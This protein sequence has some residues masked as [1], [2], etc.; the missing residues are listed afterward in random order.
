M[1]RRRMR[2]YKNHSGNAGFTL[3]EMIVVLAVVM[4]LLRAFVPRFINSFATGAD[5]TVDDARDIVHLLETGRQYAVSNREHENWGIHLVDNGTTDCGSSTAVDCVVLFKGTDFASRDSSY[6]TR[7]TLRANNYLTDLEG[8]D[9][10]F[11]RYSGYLMNT[12]GLPPNPVARYSMESYSMTRFYP[13]FGWYAFQD[14]F[15]VSGNNNTASGTLYFQPAYSVGFNG[16]SGSRQTTVANSGT[17]E[18]IDIPNTI[19]GHQA[20]TGFTYAMEV[21][22]TGSYIQSALI[23]GSQT[24]TDA[25]YKSGGIYID[26]SNKPTAVCYDGHDYYTAVASNPLV[27]ASWY[28]IAATYDASSSKLKL[29]IDGDEAAATTVTCSGESMNESYIGLNSDNTNRMNS[30][31]YL[32]DVFV[33]DR[34]LTPQQI[35]GLSIFS[36]TTTT[37]EFVP[38]KI[39]VANGVSTTTIQ[40]DSTGYADYY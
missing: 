20:S 22:T 7:V 1:L 36:R 23:G 12:Y 10:Y 14:L 21:G 24:T 26:A 15:D 37:N 19:L 38:S 31:A 28:H 2:T 11:E 33:Y 40:M 32:D 34:P 13:D 29:Y 4:L 39:Y 17:G 16:G 5:Q 8:I 25:Y 3:L 27:V 18:Q 6:D 9:P 30:Q 35:R